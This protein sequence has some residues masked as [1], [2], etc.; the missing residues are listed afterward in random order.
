MADQKAEKAR[1]KAEKKKLAADKK[2]NA[3]EAKKRAREIAKQ[4]RKLENE[5]EGSG[6]SVFVITLFIILVWLLIIGILIK[7]DVGHFGS[8]ILSPLIKDVPALSWIL[9]NSEA[10]E[11]DTSVLDGY[12]DLKAAVEQIRE[13]ELELSEAQ[14]LNA[15]YEDTISTLKAR[16][17]KLTIYEEDATKLEKEKN[18]FYEEVIYAANAPSIEEYAKWYETMEPENAEYWYKRVAQ[19][20]QVDKEFERLA[21]TFADMKPKNAAS[22]LE[23]LDDINRAADILWAMDTEARAKIMDVI[24]TEYGAKITQ[25]LDKREQ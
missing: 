21:D 13:L 15:E 1:L 8:E 7:L 11:D 6:F 10:T 4:E 3:K 24:D 14:A 18:L 12:S 5:A 19:Q 20:I 16:V 23:K 9:P 17:E 25:I 22:V 2:R